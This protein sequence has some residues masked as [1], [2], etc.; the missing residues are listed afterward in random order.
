M[1][2]RAL[3]KIDPSLDLSRHFREAADLP[4]VFDP[5]ALFE[6]TQPLEVEVGS[7]KGLFL[8]AAAG[9]RPDHS[10]LGIEIGR[11]YAR[12]AAAKLAKQASANAMM[13]CGDALLG[14]QISP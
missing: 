7:G 5:A 3:R 10:F 4:P 11:K 2:R 14:A 8:A 13:I 12:Y 9:G 6:N 1:G